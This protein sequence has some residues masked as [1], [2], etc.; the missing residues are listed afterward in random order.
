M[1]WKEPKWAEIS[2][3]ELKFCSNFYQW[4]ISSVRYDIC[5]DFWS[6]VIN[7]ENKKNVFVAHFRKAFTPHPLTLFNLRPGFCTKWKASWS[8]ISPTGFVKTAVLALILETSKSQR[9][10]HFKPTLGAFSW[11][12][13]KNFTSDATQGNIGF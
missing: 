12:L 5:Y 9:S 4:C 7:V 11:N 10:N 3:N 6:D 2:L 8:Y 13:Y 1:S